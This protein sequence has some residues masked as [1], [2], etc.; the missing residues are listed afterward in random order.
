MM[1]APVLGAFLYGR[2][3]VSPEILWCSMAG[4]IGE[5]AQLRRLGGRVSAPPLQWRMKFGKSHF[6]SC[7]FRKSV[8]K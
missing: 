8:V 4:S 1:D 5:S 3:I 2:Y 6:P 7:N